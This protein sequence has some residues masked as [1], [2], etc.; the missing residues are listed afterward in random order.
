MKSKE[1]LNPTTL[2]Y[3][4]GGKIGAFGISLSV[5]FF[6]YW[7]NIVCNKSTECRLSYPIFDLPTLWSQTNLFSL[8]VCAVYLG[9][10]FYIMTCWCLLPGRRV[11]GTILRDGSRLTYKINAFATFLCT[12]ALTAITLW[13]LGSWPFIYVV[14]HYVEF[15]TASLIM[16]VT[17]AFYCY[18]SSFRK[19][20]ILALG[21]N[22]GNFIYDWFIGRELNPRIGSFDIKTF[23]EMRPGL[24]LWALLDFCWIIKQFNDFGRVSNSILLTFGFQLWYVFDAEFNED[25]ILTQMDITTDGFGFML[26]VGDLTWVPFTYSLQLLYLSFTPIDLTLL[27][28]GSIILVQLVGYYIFR[29]SNEEKNEFRFK[30]SNPKNLTFIETKRGT[31]LLTSGW[32]GR[33]RHPNYLGDWIMAWAWCL[34]TGFQ[35]P[36]TYFYVIYFGILLVH[37]QLRDEEACAQKYGA[38]WIRYK[39]IVRWK[40]IPYIY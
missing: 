10:Y 23:N 30:K 6:T 38:D 24:I 21:G 27:E 5:P 2:H 25:T 36:I 4:F 1:T 28:L 15:I 16:S 35:T 12:C 17:Q 7:M 37:R 19:D 13:K 22:S 32:W 40:I 26:S 34:P 14:D 3:E 39:N 11:Q 8:E 20:R 31:K 9:W 33:S 18:W 29:V